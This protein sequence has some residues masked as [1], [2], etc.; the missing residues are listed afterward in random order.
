MLAAVGPV[1]AQPDQLIAR[2]PIGIVGMHHIGTG[3]RTFATNPR[4]SGLSQ[5]IEPLIGEVAEVKEQQRAGCQAVEHVAGGHLLVLGRAGLLGDAAPLL[6]AYIE[7]A[8]QPAVQQPSV[9]SS[10]WTQRT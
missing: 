10:Q 7:Q 5:V 4:V 8:S 3:A 1:V 6:A 9:P 2:L